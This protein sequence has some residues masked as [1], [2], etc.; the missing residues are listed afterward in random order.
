MNLGLLVD[1]DTKLTLQE[2]SEGI[3][4]YIQ[5]SLQKFDFFASFRKDWGSTNFKPLVCVSFI[6]NFYADEETADEETMKIVFSE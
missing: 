1:F 5:I 6:Y 2:P 4:E 3:R